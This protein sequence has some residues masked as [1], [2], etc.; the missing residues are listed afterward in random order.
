MADTILNAP[1]NQNT[2]YTPHRR[3]LNLFYLTGDSR[4]AQQ[5]GTAAPNSNNSAW[6]RFNV[7]NQILGQ[8]MTV[9]A[10][11]AISGSIALNNLSDSVVQ[12]VINSPAGW[13]DHFGYINDL[14]NGVSANQ[15]WYGYNG[16]AGCRAQYQKMLSAGLRLIISLEPGATSI[17]G[18]PTIMSELA[19]LN[20]LILEFART[21]P[22]IVLIDMPSIMRDS[23]SALLSF[24]AGLSDDGTHYTV[25][26]G[27]AQA[28]N[29]QKTGYADVLDSLV[30]RRPSGLCVSRQE[31]LSVGGQDLITNPL[32]TTLT[33]GTTSGAGTLTSGTVPSGYVL[34]LPAGTS[35]AVTSAAGAYG[36]EI[37]LAL[38]AAS[39]GTGRLQLDVTGD[40]PGD[41]FFS[42]FGYDV[43][44]GSSNFEGPWS[45]L[46]SNYT[47]TPRVAYDGWSTGTGKGAFPS[48][49]RMG[50]VSK[51]QPLTIPSGTRLWFTNYLQ[52]NFTAAG[53]ASITIRQ[54]TIKKISG[55]S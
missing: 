13:A 33:G 55:Y 7:A 30:P 29:A 11:D 49:A 50:R 3:S 44:N 40:N 18:S 2:G 48:T 51:T 32:F 31:V 36:N 4:N 17:A 22:E 47:P 54:H 41:T 20:S 16:W 6:H 27:E 14:S 12:N 26:G 43:A 39:P 19:L 45:F 9:L 52:W 53:S 28:S 21:N 34:N 15:I 5:S 1:S 38:T 46:Q 37:T 10:N 35:C 8:R 24:K 42:A 25:L 23:T